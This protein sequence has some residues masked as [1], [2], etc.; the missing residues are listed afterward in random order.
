MNG[1]PAPPR[2]AW[3]QRLSPLSWTLVGLVVAALASVALRATHRAAGMQ[4]RAL[5]VQVM[6]GSGVPELAERAA[7][8]LRARGLDVVAVGNADAQTYAETLVLL[9]RGNLDVARQV[10]AAL[11]RGRVLEQRDPALLVDVTVV[12]G[13]DYGGRKP[14]P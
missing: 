4:A 3:Y 12:L 6:N 11:G 10:A 1:R 5:Q 8:A 9:R 2:G 7:D 13:R 14:R